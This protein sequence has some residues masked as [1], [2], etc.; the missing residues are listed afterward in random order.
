M[1]WIVLTDSRQYKTKSDGLEKGRRSRKSWRADE[2]GTGFHSTQDDHIDDDDDDD[3]D[4]KDSLN[5]YS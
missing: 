5:V 2:H 4:K 3:D 1:Y